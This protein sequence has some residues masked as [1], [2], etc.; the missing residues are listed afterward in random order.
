MTMSAIATMLLPGR[1]TAMEGASSLG[2]GF[3]LSLSSGMRRRDRKR[4]ERAGP[5]RS[6][7]SAATCARARQGTPFFLSEIE[8]EDS[9][10]RRRPDGETQR[11]R[12]AVPRT[13]AFVPSPWTGAGEG[14]TRSSLRPLLPLSRGPPFLTA[15]S[16]RTVAPT[17][18]TGQY[19]KPVRAPRTKTRRCPHERAAFGGHRLVTGSPTHPA[20]C[21]RHRLHRVWRYGSR[22][23]IATMPPEGGKGG[24]VNGTWRGRRVRSKVPLVSTVRMFRRV[25]VV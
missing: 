9:Q 17:S 10:T 25:R 7:R 20:D 6:R 1:T 3:P 11:R 12:G 23:P 13:G 5:Y 15:L 14:R 22:G 4:T 19:G 21:S 2:T 18:Q 16:A 24:T 8:D